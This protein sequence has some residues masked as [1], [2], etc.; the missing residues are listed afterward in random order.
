M[1]CASPNGQTIV[2]TMHSPGNLM[3]LLLV[4]S[5]FNQLVFTRIRKNEA[6]CLTFFKLNRVNKSFYGLR[7]WTMRGLQKKGKVE[8]EMCTWACVLG[9][10]YSGR[11]WIEGCGILHITLC[12]SPQPSLPHHH[13]LFLVRSSWTLQKTQGELMSDG[14]LLLTT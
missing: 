5:W 4:W 1:Q 6:T 11:G 3:H 12:E 9:V 10:V 8:R 2:F 14:L 13:S 7:G